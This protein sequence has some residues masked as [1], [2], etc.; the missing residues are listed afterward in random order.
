MKK[1][2]GDLGKFL[3]SQEKLILNANGIDVKNGNDKVEIKEILGALDID[4]DFV[5]YG[6]HKSKYKSNEYSIT[7]V[8][9][10]YGTI[11]IEC[12]NNLIYP[13]IRCIAMC[14]ITNN[15]VVINVGKGKNFATLNMIVILINKFFEA[16]NRKDY[17]KIV[18]ENEYRFHVDMVNKIILIA[19]HNYYSRVTHRVEVPVSYYNTDKPAVLLSDKKYEKYLEEYKDSTILTTVEV[20]EKYDDY[21]MS[22]VEEA[23]KYVNERL[24]GRKLVMF[25]SDENSALKVMNECK[26]NIVCVNV[27]MNNVSMPNF[28]QMDFLYIKS[29]ISPN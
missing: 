11:G 15:N 28:N 25:T 23:I 20:D 13:I 29:M 22:S 3:K 19:S 12:E 2:L 6:K 16:L 9:D 24:N 10:N 21:Y 17:I 8:Y 27:S 18:D 14:I 1:L 4:E 26:S 5:Y 7:N